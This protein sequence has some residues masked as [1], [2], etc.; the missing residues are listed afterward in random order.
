MHE[1]S[2]NALDENKRNSGLRVVSGGLFFRFSRG[3]R[4][5]SAQHAFRHNRSDT[6]VVRCDFSRGRR[7]NYAPDV[8][9]HIETDAVCIRS[10]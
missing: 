6:V 3:R 4:Y 7:C 1:H 2:A 5:D 10:S 8:F 9:P